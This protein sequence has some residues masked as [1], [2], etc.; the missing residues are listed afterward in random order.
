MDFIEGLPRSGGKKVIMVVVDRL[1]KYANFLPLS[2]P[3]SAISVAQI[4]LDQVYKLHGSPKSII[5][6]RDKVFIS[7]FWTE[8]MK[9]LGVQLKLS[10]AYHPQTDGQSEV[11]NRCLES[12]LRCICH[13]LPQEWLKWLPLA[14]FW[15]NSTFHSVIQKTPYEVLYSQPPPVH[16]PYITVSTIV[17]AVDRSFKLREQ[18]IVVL[19]FNLQRAQNRMKQLADRK[20]SDRQFEKGEWVYLKLQA[21]KQMS[22]SNMS[23][24]KLTPKYYGPYLIIKKI[25][26]VADTLQLPPYSK[27][28]PT[29]HVSLLKKHH[30][31]P[32][33]TLDQSL[34]ISYDSTTKMSDKAP[35]EVLDIRFVKRRN[36]VVVQ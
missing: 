11:L 4:Y 31:P 34:P 33:V 14:E 18:A 35:A 9:L 6:D 29:F 1:S 8:F 12:Y 28:H 25:G 36:A 30:A 22:V 32:P 19:K 21:Y 10:I 5:S 3:F 13:D 20:R 24:N 17:E 7:K 2:H 27:I 15:Y 16:R 26:E 23:N